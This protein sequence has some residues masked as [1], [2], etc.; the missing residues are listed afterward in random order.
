[1][2][3]KREWKIRIEDILDAIR[4]I[5]QFIEGHHYQSFLTDEK[6]IDAVI[7]N[8][9]VIGE[10]AAQV[11]EEIKAKYQNIPGE[12]MKGMRNI[13]IHEYFG[14]SISSIWKT[15]ESDLPTLLVSLRDLQKKE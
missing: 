3:P 9:E 11:P 12:E 14:V 6:S 10:A 5:N 4:K 2:P 7:R 8:F 13:L 15:I 1:M